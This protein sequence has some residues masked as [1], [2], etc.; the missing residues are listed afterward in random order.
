VRF[1]LSSLVLLRVHHP[2]L[3]LNNFQ[4]K[5]E[6]TQSTGEC[7]NG[8]SKFDIDL[9]AETF[10]AKLEQINVKKRR[11]KVN[12]HIEIEM[13]HS[14]NITLVSRTFQ[15]KTRTNQC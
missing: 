4:T 1:T 5:T 10:K 13:W 8:W 9:L 15:S 7:S 2:L 3:H 6:T 11:T 14:T 12:I